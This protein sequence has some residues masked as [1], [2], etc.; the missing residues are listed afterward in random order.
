MITDC[1]I[2]YL[3]AI[4]SIYAIQFVF[5][6][7][8][9]SL[10]KKLFHFIYFTRMML[11]N[12]IGFLTFSFA[13]CNAQ[14][15]FGGFGGFPGINTGQTPYNPENPASR[16][17]N[18]YPTSGQY[19]LYPGL[20]NNNQEYNSG[21]FNPSGSNFVQPG[22]QQPFDRNN[23]N[24][25]NEFYGNQYPI[26]NNVYFPPYGG[27]QW[28][29]PGRYPGNV[30]QIEPTTPPANYEGNN[31]FFNRPQLEEGPP[32]LTERELKRLFSEY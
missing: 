7:F 14:S 19:N 27:N 11:F 21:H 5:K 16:P 25:G 3:K 10:V 6:L 18:P 1:A 22:S 24:P 8:G 31:G 23:R 28:P 13:F 4:F 15:N 29:S 2:E 17:Y 9:D 26:T 30:Y 20:Y 32:Y 12:I